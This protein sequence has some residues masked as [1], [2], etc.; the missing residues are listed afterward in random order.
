[1]LDS[2]ASV[3]WR[4]RLPAQCNCECWGGGPGGSLAG[5][6]TGIAAS[7][8]GS[9]ASQRC[10]RCSSRLPCRLVTAQPRARIPPERR[11]SLPLQRRQVLLAGA[12]VVPHAAEGK[13]WHGLGC[14]HGA[15][16]RSWPDRRQQRYARMRWTVHRLCRIRAMKPPDTA[17]L[18]AGI[19]IGIS[20][21]SAGTAVVAIRSSRKTAREQTALQ[22]SSRRSR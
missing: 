21:L 1:M 18:I 16:P 4:R 19:G 6:G 9:R 22:A 13:E 3:E 14:G 11:L 7:S 20:V 15:A 17:N 2:L 10:R 8:S 12:K 5:S